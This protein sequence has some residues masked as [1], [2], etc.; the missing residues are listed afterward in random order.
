MAIHPAPDHRIR[1]LEQIGRA[2]AADA[3]IAAL[4][5]SQHG[6]VS[7]TQLLAAGVSRRQIEVRLKRGSLHRIYRGVYTVGHNV[8]TREGRWMAAVLAAGERAALSYWSAATLCGMRQAAGPR[9][10]VTSPRERQ[11]SG[12]VTFH[13][14]HL[15]DDEVTVEQGIPVTTPART[16]LDLAPL[17][18]GPTL[19]R[20]IEAAPWSRGASLAELLDRYPRRAAG[21]KLRVALAKPMPMTR[22]DF[23]AHVLDAIERAGLP[24]PKV[25]AVV[26][27]YEVDFVWP[28]HGVI[29]ELDSYVT[30]GSR[31]AF[32][33]DRQRDR[34]LSPDWRVARLT[35]EDI[36]A[37]IED[38]SRLLAASAARS[39]RRRAAA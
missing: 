17:L 32:Q 35:D 25:N 23:E 1:G 4:A 34:R 5:A 11:N 9:S 27:G 13:C 29:A 22:S 26:E 19:A 39:P 10:H 38:L 21:E 33:R 20:M 7:R 8:L 31:A 24:Q 37:G 12:T 28:D 14:A 15:A 36:E 2:D 18:P 3:V 16:L 6:V 30:H